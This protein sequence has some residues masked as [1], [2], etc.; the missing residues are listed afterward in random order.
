MHGATVVL[1]INIAVAGMFAASFAIIAIAN[2]SQRA[3]I[4]F[5]LSYLIGAMTPISEFVLPLSNTP[6]LFMFT[7]YATF[8]AGLLAMAAALAA[9]HRRRPEWGIIAAIF[10]GGLAL[11]WLI[12][13]GQRDDLSYEMAYQ[14]P[15]ALAMLLSCR[16]ALRLGRRRPMLIALATLFGL[17]TALFVIKPFL[18]A[19]F[20]S[21]R[22]AQDYTASTYALISQA[23]TGILLIAA[24][25]LVLLHVLQR[26][27]Y[28]S[29]L[30]SEIDPLSGL[31]NRRGFDRLAQDA[32]IRAERLD[33]PFSVVMFDLDHFKAINDTFGHA[34]G[35]AVIA[36]FAALLRRSA[37][38]AAI[39][40]R[41]GG[42]EF[43][44]LI[45]QATAESAWLNAE[46]IR[47]GLA[48]FAE[49]DLPSVTVS[50]GVA[51]WRPGESFAELMRRA[52]HASYKAKNGGRDRICHADPGQE[53]IARP[54]NVVAIDSRTRQPR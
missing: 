19:A 42:E 15:F 35:D 47:M 40:G 1:V 32:L 30:A 38:Q 7:S 14:A 6:Q 50:G 27:V 53:R 20:G 41:M 54:T 24:G 44:M 10:V 3:V 28:E 36:A 46:A 31:A 49:A 16:T 8:L 45:E 4:G 51:Q 33:R 23:S 17:L 11:R 13:S 12:W 25:L 43:A 9:F 37:P 5:S 18:A 34:T 2:R 39:V 26:V 21:G 22:T 29:R 48:T 52:D